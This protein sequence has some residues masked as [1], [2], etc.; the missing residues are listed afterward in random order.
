LA[1]FIDFLPLFQET[2]ET[3][4][5]RMD[6]DVNDGIDPSDD[7]YVDTRE[8]SFYYDITQTALLEI[9]RLY[10]S[11]AT[12]VPATAFPSYAWGEYLDYWADVFGLARK[13]AVAATGEVTFYG[14]DGTLLPTGTQIAAVAT[15]PDVSAPVYQTTNSGT[16]PAQI[17]EPASIT[18]ASVTTGGAGS[19]AVGTY[20]Y[21]VACSD[22]EG[23]TEV[24]TDDITTS[25]TGR[26]DISWTAVAGAE[27]YVVYRDGEYIGETVGAA[28]SDRG[29]TSNPDI[30]PS[31]TNETGGKRTL[32]IEAT[33]TG[34]AGNVGTGS[35][36]VLLT[37]ITGVTSISNLAPI[38]GGSEVESDESLRERLLLEFQ[39]GGSGTLN[40]YKRWALANAS[41][42][43]ATVVPVWDGPGTVKVVVSDSTGAPVSNTV[44]AEVQES[45]DP[46][47]GLGAGLAPIGA[48]VTISTP[49]EV[50]I[51]VVAVVAFEDGYTLD[52]T[53]GS[54]AVR[55]QI[56]DQL[57]N[58]VNNLEPGDDVVFNHV[59][60]QFFKVRGVFDVSGVTVDG[61]TT[62]VTITTDQVA[63][64]GVSTLTE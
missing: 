1:D 22:N 27:K 53:D 51:D 5:A 30:T 62:D 23:E 44:V 28:F 42:S 64:L 8:G 60:A 2:E 15:V 63:R 25:A 40:D 57:E 10:D 41:V 38:S 46:L 12:E 24:T 59:E 14:T 20:T 32:T 58:Y 17:N 52:G 56:V 26:V 61:G 13:D 35:V 54:I 45:I 34:T 6:N 33:D 55:S 18:L 43:R 39:P 50:L 29:I 21:G 16:I 49:A 4:R 48:T 31:A 19:L 47:P 36:T 9:A 3:I 37:G 11:I 7:D